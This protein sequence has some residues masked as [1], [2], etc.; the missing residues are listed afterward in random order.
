M[1]NP[2]FFSQSGSKLALFFCIF[3]NL[4]FVLVHKNAEKNLA[5]TYYFDHMLAGQC[6][7]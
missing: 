5:N 4:N 3:M 1:M 6:V 2:C 7:M